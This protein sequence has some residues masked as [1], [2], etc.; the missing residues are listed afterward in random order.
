MNDMFSQC[1]TFTKCN[2]FNYGYCIDKNY[3]GKFCLFIPDV[4]KE[5]KIDHCLHELNKQTK[6]NLWKR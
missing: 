4:P 1:P 5:F 6:S 3:R 2:H